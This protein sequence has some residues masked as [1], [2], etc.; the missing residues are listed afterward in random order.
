[1]STATVSPTVRTRQELEITRVFDAP[2]E[3]VWKAWTNPDEMRQWFGPRDFVARN[4]TAVARPGGRWRN[5]LHSDGFDTGDGEKRRLDLW[6]GGEYLEVVEPVRLVFTFQWDEGSGLPEH[7][8]VI[9]IT[10]EENKGKT[11]MNFHQTFF[12]TEEDRDGHM[13]GWNSSFEKLDDLLREV[14]DG[15]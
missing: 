12:V 7:E 2:R 3:L 14:R 15:R 9:T 11:T 5:C 13:K 8:T 1:M 10:F 6:Q 4:L